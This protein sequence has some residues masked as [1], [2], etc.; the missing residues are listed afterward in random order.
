MEG[1]AQLDLQDPPNS[2]WLQRSQLRELRNVLPGGVCL[3]ELDHIS[4]SLDSD[5]FREFVGSANYPI[6]VNRIREKR[7]FCNFL[8]AFAQTMCL[9]AKEYLET[10]ASFALK[11]FE[12]NA[13]EGDNENE[14]DEEFIPDV[15]ESDEE[16]A[17][18]EAFWLS[19]AII[20][21]VRQHPPTTMYFDYELELYVSLAKKIAGMLRKL[22]LMIKR[23][24]QVRGVF[25]FVK[26]YGRWIRDHYKPGSRGFQRAQ[27]N[28]NY[29]SFF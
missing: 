25:W 14:Y 9:R 22:S 19:D 23:Q 21:G 11:E 20:I 26:C 6:E 17:Q 12:T 28:Y 3:R 15:K 2:W 16:R 8:K 18:R 13:E 1:T 10:I 24:R 27:N 7:I 4:E 29:F 5:R